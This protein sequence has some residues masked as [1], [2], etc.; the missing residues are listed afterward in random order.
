MEFSTAAVALNSTANVIQGSAGNPVIDTDSDG[1][2]DDE[3][4]Y[5]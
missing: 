5:K 2:L 3:P 1:D 4:L